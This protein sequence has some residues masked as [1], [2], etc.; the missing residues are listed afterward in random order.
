MSTDYAQQD[1]PVA[2]LKE[3][4]EQLQQAQEQVDEFGQEELE[5]LAE[6]YNGF[7]ALLERY[8]DQVVGDEGDFQTNI[9][10]QSQ[11]AEFTEE[12]ADDI[13]L[14]ETFDECNE[15]LK[16]RWFKTSHFEH[17][18]EQLEPV[19]DLV[20]RLETYEQRRTEYRNARK[21]LGQR[22]HDLEDKIAT[23]ER[24]VR[25]GDADLDAPTEQLRE[26][27][28]TYN[29]QVTDAF[30]TF[31]RERS[32][33]EVLSFLDTT[34][35]YP[36]VPF[37]KPP[38]ELYSFVQD[39]P[40]GDEPLSKLVDYADYS[41]SKLDHYVDN[42][43]Q[44]KHIVGGQKVFLS[45]LDSEPLRIDW[46]PPS[47]DKLRYRCRELTAVVNRLD[48]DVVETLR[49]VEQLPRETNYDQL[50]NSVMAKESL[51]DEERKRI[52]E[53]DIETQLSEAREQ[54]ARFIDAL[55]AAPKK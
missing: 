10:F 3:A 52:Q 27:I 19:A 50:R 8:E 7:V 1:D 17:V 39:N 30:A 16:Q 18:Y 32:A 49:A 29:E 23:L 38:A 41:R 33:R 44:L 28:E 46:P 9:E 21:Q 55:E 47:A 4:H 2:R 20:D 5:Q 36:L 22:I 48:Q 43:D 14:A 35:A 31:R 53:E 51:T 15:H 25:L 6:A 24:L 12:L 42:P 40:V 34:T 54:K 37:E 11:I 13:L 45:G 26:P